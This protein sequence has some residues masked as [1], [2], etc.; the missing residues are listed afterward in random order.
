MQ[1]RS[2]ITILSN[3]NSLAAMVLSL[4]T[5]PFLARTVLQASISTAFTWNV[6][7]APPLIALHVPLTHLPT[8]RLALGVRLGSFSINTIAAA[9][10][11]HLDSTSIG[12]VL[13]ACLAQ[14]DNILT[15]HLHSANHVPQTV[16]HAQSQ[17][18]AQFLAVLAQMV[19]S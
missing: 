1:P 18:I 10:R 11:V 8:L 7:T 15:R 2:L 13:S 17:T 9:K 19:S 14:V 6:R 3:A 16:R 4:T 12:I 5:I